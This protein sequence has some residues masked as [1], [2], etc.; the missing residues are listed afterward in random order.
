MSKYETPHIIIYHNFFPPKWLFLT[1][2]MSILELYYLKVTSILVVVTIMITTTMLSG[3]EMYSDGNA[4]VPTI[5]V[6]VCNNCDGV[7]DKL[8]V[9]VL[10][11]N[12]CHDDNNSSMIHMMIMMVVA[13][14]IESLIIMVVEIVITLIILMAMIK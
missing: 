1:Q 2:T 4:L 11:S 6:Q 5:T 10:C 8:V 12:N 9:L 13:S 14:D 7:V 3:I